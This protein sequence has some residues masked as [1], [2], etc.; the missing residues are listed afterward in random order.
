MMTNLSSCHYFIPGRPFLLQRN[1][2][3]RR[4]L[5][6]WAYSL[7]VFETLWWYLPL[8]RDYMTPYQWAFLTVRISTLPL[9]CILGILHSVFSLAWP[10]WW[11]WFIVV[12][13]RYR[14]RCGWL[15]K[16]IYFVAL[17]I[18]YFW[19]QCA[20]FWNI[21]VMKLTV[22]SRSTQPC[23]WLTRVSIWNRLYLAR[24]RQ[25]YKYSAK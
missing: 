3:I 24:L 5:I 15:M 12:V 10:F 19:N 22:W 17:T 2:L 4:E 25:K 16:R 21:S 23:V 7:L 11:P 18:T 8:R 14:K 6:R 13:E 9:F 1:C 20:I